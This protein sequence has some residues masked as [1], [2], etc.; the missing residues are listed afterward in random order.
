[1]VKHDFLLNI[2]QMHVYFYTADLFQ[3]LTAVLCIMLNMYNT[4]LKKNQLF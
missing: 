3:Y 4:A 1:M 2:M